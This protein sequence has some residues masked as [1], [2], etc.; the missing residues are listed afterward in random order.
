MEWPRGRVWTNS[1]AQT[2][3]RLPV[4]LTGASLQRLWGGNPWCKD[5]LLVAGKKIL[6]RVKGRSNSNEAGRCV[7]FAQGTKRRGH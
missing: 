6:G 3:P 1:V 4:R 7:K 5:I 2:R